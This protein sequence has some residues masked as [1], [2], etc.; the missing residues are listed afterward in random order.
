MKKK[1]DEK[2]LTMGTERRERRGEERKGHT[3]IYFV[4][5]T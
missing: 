3:I 4:G 2:S 1:N 5:V